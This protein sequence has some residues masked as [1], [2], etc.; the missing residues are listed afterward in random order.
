MNKMQAIILS[1]IA[2]AAIGIGIAIPFGISGNSSDTKNTDN[3]HAPANDQSGPN[4]NFDVL[5]DSSLPTIND[6]NLRVE[7]VATGLAMPTSMAF[8]DK[9]DLLITQKDNGR[10]RHILDGSLQEKP[11]HEVFVINN[12]E[13]GLLG[14]AV[15]QR[16]N[17]TDNLV[18]FLYYT[19][20]R[21]GEI[22]NRVYSYDWSADTGITGE[23]L[24][25][26]LPGTPGPN[27]DGGKLAI[28]PDGMLYAV[29]GDL[30]QNGKLQNYHEGDEPDDTSVILRVDFSGKGPPDQA[31]SDEDDSVNLSLSKYFAYGIRN[32]FGIDF[33]PVT[34]TLWDT[35]N[36]PSGYDEINVVH[37]GLNSGW[38]KVM[39][40]I[41]RTR[42]DPSDLVTFNGSQYHDP[43]FSWRQSLGITDIEFFNSTSLGTK[44]ANNIF[45]G[46]IN[47]GN[48]YFFTVNKER[49]GLSFDSLDLRDLVADNDREVEAVTIGSGFRGITDIETGP[50]GYLYIL[51]FGGNLYRIVPNS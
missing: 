11:V 48:L 20:D 15:V 44:Y 35:E 43:A 14:I 1:V 16:T 30:N 24:V 13:R 19:E 32:S 31:L 3:N 18:V 47:N 10:L 9:N 40:P 36:G 45:V 41:E 23:I 2:I 4:D 5:P 12:N 29:I 39:G 49:I 38:E 37:P 8:L 34:G 6:A 33:D 17:A 27:H 46:D 22:R 50:D 25:L 26:D 7:K 51:S 28:G 42:T 21:E